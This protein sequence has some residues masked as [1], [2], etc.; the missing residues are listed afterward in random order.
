MFSSLSVVEA[1]LKLAE[2]VTTIGSSP[3]GSISRNFEC[4]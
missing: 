4:T 3:S 1:S 2:P